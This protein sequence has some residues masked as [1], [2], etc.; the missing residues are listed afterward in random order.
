M[1]MI[2]LSNVGLLIKLKAVKLTVLM[3]WPY[4]INRSHC[5]LDDLRGLHLMKLKLSYLLECLS[6]SVCVLDLLSLGH[7]ALHSGC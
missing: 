3:V 4:S 5:I 7:S 1:Q 6:V 2:S